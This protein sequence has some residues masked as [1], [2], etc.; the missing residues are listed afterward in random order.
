MSFGCDSEKKN[1]EAGRCAFMELW[2]YLGLVAGALTS[3]G[4][5]PQILKGYATK[6]MGDVSLL[7][8]TILGLGMFLWLLYGVHERDLP[9]IVAN[10][11][12]CTF[13]ATLVVMKLRYDSGDVSREVS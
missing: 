9:I 1:Y 5:L 8:P 4:Y 3:S 2:I 10:V 12:G 7:M 11:A 6:K 13:T